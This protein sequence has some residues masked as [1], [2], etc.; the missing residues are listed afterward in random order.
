M[1][2]LFLLSIIDNERSTAHI[3]A[4]GV[5]YYYYYYYYYY[6]HCFIIIMQATKG[7]SRENRAELKMTK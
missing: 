2:L 1:V 5:N 4:G 6:Y 3:Q 7:K